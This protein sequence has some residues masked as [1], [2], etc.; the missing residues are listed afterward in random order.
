M[1]VTFHI[2]VRVVSEANTRDHWTKKHTRAKRQKSI[3][4]ATCLKEIGCKTND[5]PLPGHF[6]ISFTRVKG[7][8][9]RD[10]DCDNLVSAFKHIR[11]GI[12]MYLGINDGSEFVTFP[13]PDQIKQGKGIFPGVMVHIEGGE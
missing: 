12:C 1:N 5:D 8:G 4:Y 2:P 6:R 3:A 11:D 7:H 9:Q 13:P 10:F